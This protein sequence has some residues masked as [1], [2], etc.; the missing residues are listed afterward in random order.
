MAKLYYEH[1]DSEKNVLV[2]EIK[3]LTT[4]AWE[5]DYIRYKVSLKWQ[6][7]PVLNEKVMKRGG[8]YWNKG[9]SGAF[10][11]E[12]F[13]GPSLIKTL[14]KA[15]DTGKKQFWEAWPESDALMSVFPHA[16]LPGLKKVDKGDLFYNLCTIIFCGDI[17]QFKDSS[18]QNGGGDGVAF[19]MRPDWED[20]KKFVEDLE[21]E[22]KAVQKKDIKKAKKAKKVTVSDCEGAL[23]CLMLQKGSCF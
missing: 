16:Y 21:K 8:S 14:R 2:F 4:R 18:F 13:G 9:K 15:L 17:Y 19:V 5:E 22:F 1:G 6:G 23:R 10:L 12:E 3:V 20:Y 7:V 11:I